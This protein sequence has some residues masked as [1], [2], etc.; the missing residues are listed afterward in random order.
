VLRTAPRASNEKK[1]KNPVDEE[2]SRQK[3]DNL[4]HHD[5]PDSEEEGRSESENNKVEN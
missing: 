5:L 1:F 3:E 4:P 2:L